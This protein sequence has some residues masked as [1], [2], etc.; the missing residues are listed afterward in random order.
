METKP[1]KRIDFKHYTQTLCWDCAN[2][3]GGCTWSSRLQPVRGWQA[4]ETEIIIYR[5]GYVREGSYRV[6]SC[7]QFYRD[8]KNHGQNMLGA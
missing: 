2:A 8:A 1:K 3:C 4:E 5:N 6:I 7:P